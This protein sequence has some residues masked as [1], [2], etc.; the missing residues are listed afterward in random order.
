M[1]GGINIPQVN[2]RVKKLGTMNLV[3][4]FVFS[5]PDTEILNSRGRDGLPVVLRAAW[6]VPDT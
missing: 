6:L 4:D 1:F 2:T 5:L 3:M